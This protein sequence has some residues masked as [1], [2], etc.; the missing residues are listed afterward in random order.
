MKTSAPNVFAAGDVALAHNTTAGRPIA[1]EHWQ[2]AADQGAIAGASAAGADAQWDGVPGFWTTI[3]D[4]DLKYHAWGDGHDSS[5]LLHR[6]DGF[7]VWY[8]RD[9]ATVGVLTLNADDDY[10]LGERLIKEESPPPVPM[11]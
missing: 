2:D 8:V 3:G 1:V 10:D 6:D 11:A 4:S 9:G 5:R 7:T